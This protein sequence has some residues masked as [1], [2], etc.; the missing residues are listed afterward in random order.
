METAVM[1]SSLICQWCKQAQEISV[2]VGNL[3]DSVVMRPE[4]VCT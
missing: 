3:Y 2:P 1:L 4:N